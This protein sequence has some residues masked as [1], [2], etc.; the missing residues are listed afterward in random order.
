MDGAMNR[1]RRMLVHLRCQ[2]VT[3]RRRPSER[4]TPASRPE[5]GCIARRGRRRPVTLRATMVGQ[6]NGPVAIA[7][8]CDAA[9]RLT[10]PTPY[11]DPMARNRERHTD[12]PEPGALRSLVGAGPSQVGVVGALR[13]RDVSRPSEADLRAAL[14]KTTPTTPVARRTSSQDTSG[15]GSAGGTPVSS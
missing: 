11:A 10:V 9:R 1:L 4:V 6:R 15:S 2:A 3:D 12:A 5:A 7:A 8:I 14:A 13:A